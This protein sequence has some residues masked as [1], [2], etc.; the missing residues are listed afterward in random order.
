MAKHSATLTFH[1][2]TG[3]VTGANFLLNTGTKNVLIDCGLVQKGGF[4]PLENYEPF[5]Y[6]PRDMHVL[7]VTHAH[8]DH[9]GRIPKLVCEGFSGPIYSTPATRDLAE[10]MF[11][12]AV[13]ILAEEARKLNRDPLYTE[14]DAHDAFANWQTRDY[15][16][17]FDVGDG[18]SARFLDAGHILGSAMV[19]FTRDG[20]KFVATGDL[21]N[22]PAPL[23]PDTERVRGAHYLLTESVYGDRVHE[24][25]E[26]RTTLLK[27]TLIETHKQ[28]RTLLI[29]AFAMQRTQIL[30]YYINKMVEGGEVPE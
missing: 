25:R 27:E 5:P 30:L 7:L 8:A 15:H 1:G 16:E 26:E 21:G 17:V 28:K 20:K 29:P 14:K 12:D 4:G 24:K 19:E 22:S 6:E 13:G 2:G 11:D 23:L 3:S 10:I 9:I 18:V